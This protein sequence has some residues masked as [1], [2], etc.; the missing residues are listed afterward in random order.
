MDL[1]DKVVVIAG[2]SQGI[3]RGIALRLAGRKPR[4]IVLLARRAEV[5]GE[6]VASVAARGGVADAVSVDLRNPDAVQEAGERIERRFGVPDLVVHSTGAGRFFSIREGDYDAPVEAM[7]STY[8]ASYFLTKTFVKAM[9]A[10][11]SGHFVIVSS[12]VRLIRFF[13]NTYKASRHALHGFAESLRYELRSSGVGVTYAEPSRISDS[14]YFESNVGTLE[15][16]PLV[17]RDDRFRVFHQTSEQAGEMILEGVE[18]NAAYVAPPVIRALR[19]AYPV[20]GR[21]IDWFFE[22]TSL[23]TDRGGPLPPTVDARP[24]ARR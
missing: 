10:R 7:A 4:A 17:F 13:A 9:V 6:A 23:P 21:P 15:R 12:P 24:S 3:G 19:L 20:L 16:L 8:F 2:G 18:R 14:G 11:R 1:R 22:R 5:L